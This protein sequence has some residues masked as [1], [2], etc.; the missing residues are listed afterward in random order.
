[1]PSLYGK[2]VKPMPSYTYNE[3]SLSGIAFVLKTIKEYHLTAYKTI[4]S[5]GI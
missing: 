4:Q 5:I 1:M 2:R 3:G